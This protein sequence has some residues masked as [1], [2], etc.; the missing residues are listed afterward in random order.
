MA[1]E[2]E[3]RT[4]DEVGGQL[5]RLMRLI[6]RAQAQYLA[7]HP[8]AVDRATYLLLVH[9][10]KDGPRRASALAEAVHSDPST[11]SRQIAHLVRLGHVER[12]AD[13]EDGRATLLVATAEGRRVFEENRLLRNRKIAALMADWPA[14][15]RRVL[16]RLLAR[17]ATD[18]E[19]F[20]LR[21]AEPALA[22]GS[23]ERP[24][25]S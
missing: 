9:L 12:V 14:E 11:V 2:E 17:L 10:V 3:L 23:A 22:G 13:P 5:M 16:A 20:R 18:F 19:N 24:A 1:T 21:A 15:D 6:E 8:D 4:A 25:Q 7:E